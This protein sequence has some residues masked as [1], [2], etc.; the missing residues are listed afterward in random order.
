MK[1]V[2]GSTHP[3]RYLTER[4]ASE[5]TRFARG[6]L[7]NHR[8]KGTGPRFIRFPGHGAIRYRLDD[9]VDWMESGGQTTP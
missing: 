1:H 7:R 2:P 4:E 8:A 9:L 5:L 6:T 3:T